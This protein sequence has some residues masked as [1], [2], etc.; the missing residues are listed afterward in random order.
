VR[1]VSIADERI[2]RAAEIAGGMGRG[3]C[4]DEGEVLGEAFLALVEAEVSGLPLD[5]AESHIRRKCR[6]LESTEFQPAQ[7]ALSSSICMFK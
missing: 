4:H 6:N 7:S 3:R 1:G 5:E 2:V